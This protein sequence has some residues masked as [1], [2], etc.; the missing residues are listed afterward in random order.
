M[1][2]SEFEKDLIHLINN[3]PSKWEGLKNFFNEDVLDVSSRHF[4]DN[5][6]AHDNLEDVMKLIF[7]L[8]NR[9]D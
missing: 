8:K 3:I 6:N 9:L 5:V 1:K 7:R 4:P 2:R